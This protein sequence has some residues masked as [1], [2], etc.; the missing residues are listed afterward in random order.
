MHD[1]TKS[2]AP[3]VLFGAF[4]R[5][6]FGDLLFAH[7][8]G[9]SLW[10]RGVV[11][12][13]LAARDLREW[14][15]HAVC[16]FGELAERSR[17]GALD[18]V[19]VG[20]ELLTCDAWEAAVMLAPPGRVSAM[21]GEESAWRRDPAGWAQAHLGTASRAPYVISKASFPRVRLNAVSFHAVGGAALDRR[22]AAFRA[23]VFEKLREARH[24]S[25]RDAQTQAHLRAAGIEA[26]LV[27]DPAAMVARRFGAQIHERSV[28]GEVKA[29]LDAFAH[30]SRGYMALQFDATFGDDATLD[31]LAR[32][33]ERAAKEAGLGIVLFRAGAAPWHDDLDVYRRLAA[34]IAGVPMHLFTSLHLWDICALIAQGR[35]YCGSSLHGR[36]VAMAFARPRINLVHANEARQ[37]PK[38]AAYAATW[39]APGIAAT[40]TPDGLAEAIGAALGTDAR[41]MAYAADELVRRYGATLPRRTS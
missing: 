4:D 1:P 25:V 38:H 41:L 23:E 18:L 7:I 37:S 40:T 27:P 30:G 15:G 19:H 22:D 24:V 17:A 39:E 16:A 35:L 26:A 9:H 10:P 6:N 11:H 28:C 21:I 32:E 5:H 12:A 33:L 31:T 14:G 3:A 29:V 34:R 8:V 36:I 20:G 2:C 13:G